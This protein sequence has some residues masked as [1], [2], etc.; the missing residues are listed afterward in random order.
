MSTPFT[1]NRLL[2]LAPAFLL[3]A[4]ASFSGGGGAY[5]PSARETLGT[6]ISKKD[7][8]QT[9]SQSGRSFFVPIGK[10]LVSITVD[11]G[12]S[13]LPIFAHEIRLDDGRTVT[14]YSWYRE[15]TVGNCVKVFESE[16]S[17]YPRLIPFSG[18]AK[19]GG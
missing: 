11:R 13:G 15:H 7:T 2:F 1:R 6:V 8:G 19:V 12:P 14:V 17:D 3:A 10:Q 5:D 9:A 16:R 4:C 18:C